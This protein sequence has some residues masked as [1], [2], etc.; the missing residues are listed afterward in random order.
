MELKLLCTLALTLEV[1]HCYM[2]CVNGGERV[3]DC[4]GEFFGV[5]IPIDEESCIPVSETFTSRVD[6]SFSSR[7][8]DVLVFMLFYIN[9]EYVAGTIISD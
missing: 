6:R 4:A 8:Y 5:W 3:G 9:D 7:R 1:I 2:R